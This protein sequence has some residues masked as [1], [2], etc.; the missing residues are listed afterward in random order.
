[1]KRLFDAGFEAGM[2]A[3]EDKQHGDGG[4]RSVDG[5]PDWHQMARWCQTHRLN[6]VVA[7]HLDHH[8]AHALGS[9]EQLPAVLCGPLPAWT[10]PAHGWRVQGRDI[11]RKETFRPARCRTTPISDI[12]LPTSSHR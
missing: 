5:L 9:C 1:M 12:V 4:F 11:G 7:V 2:R 6:A 3:A 10:G 8:V